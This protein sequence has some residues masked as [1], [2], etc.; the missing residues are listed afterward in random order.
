MA[1]WWC[2]CGSSSSSSSSK[3]SLSSES[4]ISSISSESSASSLSSESSLSSSSESA[5]SSESS[6]SVESSESSLSSISSSLGSFCDCI[7]VKCAWQWDDLSGQWILLYSECEGCQP[8]GDGGPSCICALP[9]R[10]GN[11]DGEI[12]EHPC[13]TPL[14][15]V[16]PV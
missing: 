5:F 7:S 16:E 10:L 4:S 8:Q 9:P 15:S 2:C 14:P 1:W 6:L 11:Y 3:S 12:Y 13:L